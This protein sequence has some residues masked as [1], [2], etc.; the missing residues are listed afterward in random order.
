MTLF[1]LLE[2]IARSQRLLR[3]FAALTVT[4]VLLFLIDN[5][6]VYWTEWPGITAFLTHLGVLTAPK[7]FKELGSYA[8]A[9]GWVQALGFA[10]V[11]LLVTWYVIRT[12]DRAIV[13]DAKLYDDL[14]AYFVRTAFWSV[15]LVGF[16]DSMISFVRVEGFLPYLVGDHLA[17]QLGRSVF[18]GI[19]VHYPL[20]VVA[21]VIALFVRSI[22]FIW[23]ALLIV[24][25]EFTIVI[26]RFVFSYEQAF[27][28][29]V[30]RFWYAG[31]FLFASAYT[32]VHD[33]HVRVDVLYTNFSKRGKA[34]TNAIGSI[35][36]GLPLCWTILILGTESRGSI[37]IG[38]LLSYEI[39]QSGFGMY[40]KYLMAAYLMVFAI[41]MAIQ[42]VSFFLTNMA[43]F[44]NPQSDLAD[45]EKMPDSMPQQVDA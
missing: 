9:T 19:W 18:R 1:H 10:I 26:S 28:G 36:L 12:P 8:F 17:T 20:I 39:S 41:T 40:T 24:A 44:T 21:S 38:P 43:K 30:V 33:G 32:L 42:F 35:V 14:A 27:Q 2:I 4:A 29:D 6:F 7:N 45:L 15:F 11:L 23:L 13:K 16:A 5:F 25:A 31:L 22:G 34:A 37:V 3:G